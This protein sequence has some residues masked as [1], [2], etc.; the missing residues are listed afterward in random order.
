MAEASAAE[1]RDNLK[2]INDAVQVTAGVLTGA[3]RSE[4]LR[5]SAEAMEMLA[6][7]TDLKAKQETGA[8]HISEEEA[9]AMIGPRADALIARAREIQAAEELEAQRAEQIRDRAIEREARSDAG[10]SPSS[11]QQVAEDRALVRQAETIAAKE[12]QEAQAAT[13][14]ARA[15]AAHPAERIDP[16]LVKGERLEDLA[17]DQADRINTKPLAAEEA[18]AQ[19][20]RGQ[21]Q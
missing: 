18:E 1:M 3:T 11:L 16:N 12:R 13:E 14:A 17:H 6:V 21:R 10:T 15:I 19:K 2:D 4:F 20:P 8:T 7:R 5:R 9:R